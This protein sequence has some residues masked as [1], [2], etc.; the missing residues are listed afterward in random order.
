MVKLEK[1]KKQYKDF[2]LD[3]SMEI[4]EGWITGLVGQNGAGKSTAFKA[5]LGLIRSDSGKNSG[6]T[7]KRR[8]GTDWCGNGRKWI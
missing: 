7:G 5:M 3:C 6:I 1:V 4:K 8:T 2:E